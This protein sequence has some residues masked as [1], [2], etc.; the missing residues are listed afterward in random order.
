MDEIIK[1]EREKAQK[2]HA[3][4]EEEIAALQASIENKRTEAMQ[5]IKRLEDK[6]LRL[7]SEKKELLQKIQSCVVISFPFSCPVLTNR[8]EDISSNDGT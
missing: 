7:E 2:D 8:C 4:L 1:R 5:E 3:P 6:K